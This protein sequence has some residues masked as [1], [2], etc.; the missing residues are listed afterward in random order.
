MTNSARGTFEAFG[1]VG[2]CKVDG[3][4]TVFTG[5][6]RQSYL[7]HLSTPKEASS[8]EKVTPARERTD[9]EEDS[10]TP[11]SHLPFWEGPFTDAY[12]FSGVSS[13]SS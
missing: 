1:C 2:V 7:R 13:R 6:N 9:C 5:R 8:T 12:L 11:G 4:S 10:P 3:C